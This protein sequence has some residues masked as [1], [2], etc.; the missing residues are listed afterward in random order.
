[1]SIALAKDSLKIMQGS[2]YVENDIVLP[3]SGTDL[4]ECMKKYFSDCA[5]I[6]IWNMHA[7]VWGLL[8]DG[9]LQLADDSE[10]D[11]DTILELRIF[12]DKAE[13][14]LVKNGM[15]F[16]GRYIKDDGEKTIKYVDSLARFW[17]EKC[18]R[19]EDFVVLKD[20]Q[21]KLVLTVPCKEEAGFYGLVT[22][23]Y[24]GYAPQNGQAG[25]VD[26]RYVAVTSVEG[27]K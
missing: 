9:S 14:R 16:V 20:T 11:A 25:Y 26:Y 19:Q 7:V 13:L 24:I 23:N 8:R 15:S 4:Q 21:R 27:G 22:R 1:M 10:L 2:F 3:A 5:Q 17:G 18:E 6:V 12:N